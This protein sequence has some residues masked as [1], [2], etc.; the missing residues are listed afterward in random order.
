MGNHGPDIDY[1]FTDFF[2]LRKFRRR[3][4]GE[5]I[6]RQFFKRFAGRWQIDHLTQ[7]KAAAAFW[8]KV[9]TRYTRGNFK[10]KSARCKDVRVT[11]MQFTARR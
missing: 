5:R 10:K 2:V 4:A 7:N 1:S 6:A 3:G 11:I 9:I 8:K